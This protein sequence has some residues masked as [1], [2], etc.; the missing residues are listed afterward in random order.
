[1]QYDPVCAAQPVQ[2]ITAP[3]YPQYQT[4]GNACTA[5]VAG[6]TIIHKGECLP[7]ETGPYIPYTPA[8]YNPPAACKAWF[9]GCNSCSRTSSGVACT[10]KYCSPETY[11]QGYCIAWNNPKPVPPVATT[12]PPIYIPPIY[13]PP[14]YVPPIYIPPVQPWWYW[15]SPWQW[16][17][18]F[19]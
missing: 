12:T 7:H 11:Q 8:P 14:V 3:C 10:K 15:F 16:N 2:C 4:F 6:A 9:D 5:G 18:R 19:W 1:M 17:W 13:T